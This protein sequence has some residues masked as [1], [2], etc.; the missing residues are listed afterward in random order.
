MN[1]STLFGTNFRKLLSDVEYPQVE[2]EEKRLQDLVELVGSHARP[3]FLVRHLRQSRGRLHWAVN[4]YFREV[5]ASPVPADG[6]EDFAPKPLI[7]PRPVT[8][9]GAD[10]GLCNM[11]RASQIQRRASQ[12]PGTGLMLPQPTLEDV[13]S[14]CGVQTVCTAAFVSREFRQA[15]SSNLVWQKLYKQ[16]WGDDACPASPAPL[17]DAGPLEPPP[18]P[19]Q[20]PSQLESVFSIHAPI[21]QSSVG[22]SWSYQQDRS[23]A[24]RFSSRP[25]LGNPAEVGLEASDA[26]PSGAHVTGRCEGASSEGVGEGRGGGL[27]PRNGGHPPGADRSGFDGPV[28]GGASEGDTG[29]GV[30]KAAGPPLCAQAARE[31]GSKP[32]PVA[33]REAYILRHTAERRMQCPTCVEGRITPV[34]YGFPS[35]ELIAGMKSWRLMLGG[36]YMMPALPLWGCPWCSTRFDRF[37][38]APYPA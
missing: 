4:S 27:S 5:L 15:A 25:R 22:A 28:A 30:G 21:W 10:N 12:V 26:G 23:H 16:R 38:F 34:L 2:D 31:P 14:M 9:L 18:P 32:A 8:V 20:L 1:T 6:R 24:E 13:L 11:V 33:W 7:L 3:E 37:P 29:S 36:D 19:R 35:D 17:P